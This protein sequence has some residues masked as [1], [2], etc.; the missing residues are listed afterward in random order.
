MPDL[1]LLT[2]VGVKARLQ[3]LEP[4]KYPEALAMRGN[5]LSLLNQFLYQDFDHIYAKAIHF[6]IHLALLEVGKPGEVLPT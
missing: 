4:A 1:A 5:V 3:G 6:V 2:S